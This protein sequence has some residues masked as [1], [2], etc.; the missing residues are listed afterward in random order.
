MDRS[1]L[2][3]MGANFFMA[4]VR[5]GLGPFLGILLQ[6]EGWSPAAIGMVMSIGLF[7]AM[8]ITT[9]L[10]MFIDATRAKRGILV[11]AI[12]IVLASSAANFILP[13]F[14]IVVSARIFTAVAGAAV[15]PCVASISLGLVG[16][17]LFPRQVG[18]NEAS[19]RAGNAVAAAGAG[20]CGYFYGLMGVLALLTVMGLLA[21]L[22]LAL[23]DARRI[24]HA[25]A[26]SLS[27]QGT[28]A[29]PAL[30]VI[31]ASRPLMALGVVVMLYHM[32]NSG[33]TPL[34][35]QAMAA[36]GSVDNPVVYAAITV[37]VAQ[38][39]MAAASIFA[40]WLAMRRGY[41]ICLTLA[42][43]ALPMRGLVT[44]LIEAPWVVVPGQ[45]LDGIG[46]GLI[47]VA[48]IGL[49]A[50]IMEGTGH[51]TAGLGFVLTMHAIGA[52]CSA[53]IGGVVA[54]R[55][56][57]DAAFLV[58]GGIATFG[59]AI[60]LLLTPVLRQACARGEAGTPAGNAGGQS[61]GAGG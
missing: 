8:A 24:D 23:V 56:G 38:S 29:G 50:R 39:T 58:L 16:Q 2:G 14:G 19:F 40:A 43:I 33:M 51:A 12:A 27:A 55:V 1:V 47:A 11:V 60:R 20:F 35:S 48:A 3:L 59:L 37:L 21:I 57:Y 13:E 52:A 5:D 22:A 36:R 7:S 17:A 41:G 53:T 45:V 28:T 32:G 10:G 54:H 15:G 42:L 30:S 9:P 61:A 34:L 49:A 4:D 18:R 46:G 31:L 6:S 26:R 25:A 44:G